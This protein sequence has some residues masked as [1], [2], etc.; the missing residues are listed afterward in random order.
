M[1]VFHWGQRDR[2]DHRRGPFGCS[3]RG[4]NL[5][6][7]TCA[8][9]RVTRRRQ[10]ARQESGGRAFEPDTNRSVTH[11]RASRLP[12]KRPS[13]EA[14]RGIQPDLGLGTRDGRDRQGGDRDQGEDRGGGGAPA[15]AAVRGRSLQTRG[16]GA[17]RSRLGATPAARRRPRTTMTD[18][19]SSRTPHETG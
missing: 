9:H 5:L 1:T 10:V 11:R 3:S 12:P 15:G 18:A 6:D 16:G 17:P 8:A 4:E 14:R 19:L 7:A 13:V 2:R